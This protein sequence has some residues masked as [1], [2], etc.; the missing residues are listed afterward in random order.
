MERS[1][2]QNLR[3]WQEGMDLVT[4]V[5]KQMRFMPPEE[6]YGLNSQMRRAS[7]SI[8]SNIAEGRAR[9]KKEFSHFL[10]IALGSLF[11][12]ETQFLLTINLEMLE[13]NEVNTIIQKQIVPLKKQ[14]NALINKLSS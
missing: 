2:F 11:E 10:K 12:L 13:K 14:I 9:G 1:N 3:I 7:V 6:L 5:Y 4:V 8:P